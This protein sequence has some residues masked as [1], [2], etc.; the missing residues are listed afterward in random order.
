MSEKHEN[1]PSPNRLL[2]HAL[3][4]ACASAPLGE[5]AV[6]TAELVAGR[7]YTLRFAKNREMPSARFPCCVAIYDASGAL[8]VGALNGDGL[9]A[10]NGWLTFTA[11][12]T[13]THY[14][15]TIGHKDHASSFEFSIANCSPAAMPAKP[16]AEL[17]PH[18]VADLGD[19]AGPEAS[20]VPVAR[21]FGAGRK[22][23]PI[24]FALT[25][26]RRVCFG[27][28]LPETEAA[29]CLQDVD[30]TVLCRRAFADETGEWISRTLAP[31]VY[32]LR[33]E[34]SGDNDQCFTLLYRTYTD[35][36]PSVD[37]LH[38]IT[39]HQELSGLSE[40][41]LLTRKRNDDRNERGTSVGKIP[42]GDPDTDWLRYT[43]I[44]GNESGLFELDEHTGELFFKGSGDLVFDGTKE[45][46]LRVRASDGER[47]EDE[48]V[49][50]WATNTPETGSIDSDA[51]REVAQPVSY[52][53]RISLGRVA[54]NAP[55]GLPV[56]YRLVAGNEDGFFELDEE[57]GELFFT[58]SAEDLERIDT[59]LKLSFRAD[60]SRH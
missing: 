9:T 10:R 2:S 26:T 29:L 43:L 37:V 51:V 47:S 4:V 23:V 3:K 58:G 46:K 48:T 1:A 50:V 55:P 40:F 21:H 60:T 18:G 42:V 15:V 28:R 33:L 54:G 57:T 12:R 11:A 24:R 35:D 59:A 34:M 6:K 7:S 45:F 14:V 25:A 30:G 41:A 52:G 44:A 38:A 32:H 49:V 56:R 27:L 22:T 16:E 13:G 17:S 20:G 19:I 5:G 8:L 53:R 36:E 39:I 31:G